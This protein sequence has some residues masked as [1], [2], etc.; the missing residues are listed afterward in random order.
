MSRPRS[1]L[2]GAAAALVWAAVEPIDRRIFRNDYS[3]I[4]LLGKF[5]TRTRAWPVAGLTIHAV[6]G[7]VFGL[8]FDEARRRTSVRPRRLAVALALAEHVALFP[9]SYFVDERHPA[10]GEAGVRNVLSVRGF[11]QATVRHAI[12]GSVLGRIAV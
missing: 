2:A 9:L 5:V 7:A 11:A 4:A 6:N 1:A 12:F 8:A 10:R 3:D